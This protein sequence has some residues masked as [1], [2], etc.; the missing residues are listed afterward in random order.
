MN[1]MR[2]LTYI[3]MKYLG[4]NASLIP[5]DL[6]L[7]FDADEYSKK[8]MVLF[9]LMSGYRGI[10][11]L[12]NCIITKALNL[13]GIN[14][15]ILLCNSEL[16]LCLQKT[17]GSEMSCSACCYVSK[18]IVKKLYIPVIWS[19]E[20]LDE[21]DKTNAHSF[22]KSL[23]FTDYPH[24]TYNGVKIGKYAEN[25]AKRYLQV[26]FIPKTQT[27]KEIFYKYLVSACIEVNL[28]K[29]LFK[30]LK[31]THIILSNLAYLPGVFVEFFQDKG[32]DC[33]ACDFGISEGSINLN[34]L[35]SERKTLYDVSSSSWKECSSLDIKEKDL[36]KFENILRNRKLGRGMFVN[37]GKYTKTRTTDKIFKKIDFDP[38]KNLS[39]LFTNLLW[40]AS[41]AEADIGFENQLE[42]IEYTINWFSE[43]PKKNL[44]VKVHPAEE[45]I[46][47]K[48]TVLSFIKSKFPKLPP[49]IKI[50]PS[51]S[52]LNTYDL[53]KIMDQGMVYTSTAGLEM[54]IEGIPV[55]VNAQTHYRGKG[56]TFDINNIEE[57]F[58]NLEKLDGLKMDSKMKELANKYGFIH[59]FKRQIPFKFIEF[60]KENFSSHQL[61]LNHWNELLVGKDKYLDFICDCIIN[62]RDFYI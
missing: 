12:L 43:N 6:N 23:N 48:Q 18:D 60:R 56:F 30:S 26:G 8:Y 35:D 51:K 22:I 31:P 20:F 19:H 1:I 37:Y 2:E 25:A 14:S 7:K 53:Y 4:P 11:V 58:E 36:K 47:T 5:N 27:G 16:P 62:H 46:G 28:S 42:W 41:L 21:K 39:G 50:L 40:D 49:N 38:D 59:F 24:V 45:I 17:V 10:E 13:R 33:I 32:V 55:L 15:H 29:R 54:A 34:H 52:S 9:P 61:K 44:L 3:Y 57:Y